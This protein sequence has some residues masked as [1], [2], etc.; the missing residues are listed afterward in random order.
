MIKKHNLSLNSIYD[1]GCGAGNIL[2]EIQ[3]K[4]GT[5]I[6]L[7]GFDISPQA[8]SI[9]KTKENARLK[10]FNEDIL[11]SKVPPT[12]LLLLLDVFEHVPDY[13]SFLEDLSKKSKWFIF[14]IPLEVSVIDILLKSR[15]ML[16]Q[17]RIYGHLHFFTRETALAVLSNTGYTVVDYFYTDDIGSSNQPVQ[18]SFVHRIACGVRK[19]LYW[20]NQDL[21]V[22]IFNSY[23]L[24]VLARRNG[25]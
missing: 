9:A 20:I 18:G 16:S 6:E 15:R 11:T 3:Q 17:R 13:I 7:S 23:N 12:D 10:F 21:P 1:V 8:I 5:E 22:P 14:H 4:W 19:G 24:L 25:S 2:A